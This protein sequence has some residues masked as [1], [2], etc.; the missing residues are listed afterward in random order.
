MSDEIPPNLPDG[1]TLD[2]AG[3]PCVILLLREDGTV[4]ARFTRNV[5]PQEVRRAAEGE[6]WPTRF[7]SP[8][9]CQWG[10]PSTRPPVGLGSPPPP[11]RRAPRSAIPGHR[12]RWH[13]VGLTLC[14]R[15]HLYA[16][17]RHVGIGLRAW[18]GSIGRFRPAE[19]WLCKILQMG[20]VGL[21][22]HALR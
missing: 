21:S 20:F 17:P 16:A 11:G 7:V 5:D 9:I 18:D 1:Y 10:W 2:L 3:D 13:V 15:A 12:S 4:V 6:F 22:F 8:V 14:G 19:R